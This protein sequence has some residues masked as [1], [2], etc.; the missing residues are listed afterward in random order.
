M[1]AKCKFE[2]RHLD[3]TTA[4]LY[5]H[6]KET[7]YLSTPDGVEI[8]EGHVIKLNRSLYGLKQSPRSWNDRFNEFILKL[9]FVRSQADY[10][11]Y[12]WQD[13]QLTIY[14]LIYVDDTL[15]VGN[16][17]ELMIKIIE[18]LSSEF[19]MKDIGSVKRFMGLNVNISSESISIDQC[20][21]IDKILTKFNMAN[22]NSVCTPMEVG[23]KLER[24]TE[25]KSKLPYRELIGS[26]MYLAMGSRPDLSFST[27][28]ET[29]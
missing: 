5:G 10:C 26:L 24:G 29:V 1:A 25:T 23:L 7:V 18:K 13:G 14:L 27:L 16:A 15:M 4:F 19:K 8:P 12:F 28:L 2:T 21:Y 11:L 3:V 22:C 6:L 17:T 9:G 20:H